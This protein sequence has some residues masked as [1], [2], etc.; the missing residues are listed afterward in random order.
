MR[1]PS[2]SVLLAA[3]FAVVPG[4]ASAGAGFLV[5]LSERT[6]LNG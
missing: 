2:R 1:H 4:C 3:A 5:S 6:P